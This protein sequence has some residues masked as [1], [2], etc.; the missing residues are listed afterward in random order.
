MGDEEVDLGR[1][2]AGFEAG[3]AE[4]GEGEEDEGGDEGFEGLEGV[5][6]GEG[7]GEDQGGVLGHDDL[8]VDGEA[9]D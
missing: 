4:G 2:E 9:V 6:L 3:L 8:D 7:P 5:D 1:A